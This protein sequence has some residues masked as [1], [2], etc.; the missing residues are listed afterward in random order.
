MIRIE[1]GRKEYLIVMCASFREM[2]LY[3]I[4]GLRWTEDNKAAL[5]KCGE[6]PSSKEESKDE[7]KG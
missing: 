6:W 7:V 2:L 1:K 3:T 4:Y 5:V